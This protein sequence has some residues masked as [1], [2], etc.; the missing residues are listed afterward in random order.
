MPFSGSLLEL[1]I[2][3]PCADRIGSATHVA[4]IN[5]MSETP[6]FAF[7]SSCLP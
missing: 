2:H 3:F 6:D 7:V 1:D 4:V 5:K